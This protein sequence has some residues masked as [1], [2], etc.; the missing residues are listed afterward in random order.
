ML[1][2]APNHQLERWRGRGGQ[3]RRRKE[4][5]AFPAMS[6]TDAFAYLDAEQPRPEEN[7]K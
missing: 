5:L 7:G 6:M 3:M 1:S 4:L 2:N